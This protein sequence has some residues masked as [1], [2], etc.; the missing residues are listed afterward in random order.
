MAHDFCRDSFWKLGDLN[1]RE[2]VLSRDRDTYIYIYICATVASTGAAKVDGELDSFST[3]SRA[4]REE[5][6]FVESSMKA[7]NRSAVR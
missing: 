5:F 4:S 3:R 1:A 7:E 2:K 6:P